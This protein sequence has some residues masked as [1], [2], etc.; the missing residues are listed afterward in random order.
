MITKDLIP[1]GISA[2][3]AILIDLAWLTYRQPYH[4]KLFESIQKAPMKVKILP[5]IVV[6]TMIPFAAFFFG[7][8]YATSYSDALMRGAFIGFFL[9]GFY[10]AT[11]YS[12]FNN[13]TFNMAIS[14]TLWGT[15]LC[16]IVSAIGYFSIKNI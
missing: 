15:F 16:A 13:W 1:F 12:T 8:K 10:D 5:A 11:N 3:S 7:S 2:I 9:Y 14:D 6:Y 4:D